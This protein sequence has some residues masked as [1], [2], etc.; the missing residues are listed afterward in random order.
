MAAKRTSKSEKLRKALRRYVR[1]QGANFLEDPNITSIGVGRK[2]GD[3]KVGLVFT[4]GQKV[5]LE[6]LESLD[7]REIPKEIEIEGM[8]VAT[9]VLERNYEP[10]FRLVA[11]QNANPLKSRVDP[12]MPGVSVSHFD[13]TAGTLGAVVFDSDTGAPCILSNWHVLHRAS[14]S[15]GDPNLR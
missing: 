15:I 8:K 11:T 10:S 13:G 2:N 7:T 5:E 1:S 9:D 14:G 4:V 3:G 12:M 6:V